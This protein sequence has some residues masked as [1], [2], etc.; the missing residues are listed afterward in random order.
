MEFSLHISNI[1]DPH[2]PE[3]SSGSGAQATNPVQ[4][5]REIYVSLMARF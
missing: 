2:H 3:F 4:V 5:E 1:F